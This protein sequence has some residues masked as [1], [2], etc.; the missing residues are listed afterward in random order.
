[1]DQGVNV[2]SEI[3]VIFLKEDFSSVKIYW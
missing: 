1:M 3:D 2:F